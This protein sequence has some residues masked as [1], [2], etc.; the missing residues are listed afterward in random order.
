[1]I[2]G[3]KGS[4]RNYGK[5][6][7][8]DCKSCQINF[9]PYHP[10][11]KYCSEGCQR[12]AAHKQTQAWRI[13]N[14]HKYP[15]YSRKFLYNLDSTGYQNMLKIQGYKCAI[16]R[17]EKVL[18]VDHCH[19]LNII[20]GLLCNQCNTAIGLFKDNIESLYGAI[21]YLKKEYGK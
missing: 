1:M 3:L 4:T 17:L 12:I 14:P 5:R 11:Q 2:T 9:T 21:N 16:C 6:Q 10:R 13:K 20:R 7:N 18:V 15:D 8:I 19:N